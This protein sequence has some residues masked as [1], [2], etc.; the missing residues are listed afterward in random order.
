MHRWAAPDIQNTLYY[1]QVRLSSI[2]RKR[3][4]S[5]ETPSFNCM[6]EHRTHSTT[7]WRKHVYPPSLLQRFIIR[8]HNIGI[9]SVAY[10]PCHSRKL[11]LLFR[12]MRTTAAAT[13]ENRCSNRI[14]CLKRK[15][16]F[17]TSHR[18]RSFE[19]NDFPVR[20]NSRSASITNEQPHAEWITRA[21]KIAFAALRF[22]KWYQF[23]SGEELM[24]LQS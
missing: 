1:C 16:M 19:F 24:Y 18:V 6:Q 5:R 14:G 9:M 21:N 7:Q 13:T 3:H 8:K 2:G 10:C 23:A 17:F 22:W 12:G 11:V 15:K 4:F 20:V